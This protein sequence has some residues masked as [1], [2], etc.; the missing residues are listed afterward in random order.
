ML[1]SSAI[2]YGGSTKVTGLVPLAVSNVLAISVTSSSATISWDTNGDSTSQVFYGTA[3][4]NY[5]T[6]TNI[7]DY[8][9]GVSHHS[10]DLSGLSANITYHYKVQSTLD[11][12]NIIAESADETFTTVAADNSA[13][14]AGGGGGGSGGT[15]SGNII[16]KVSDLISTG[17]LVMDSGGQAKN[18]VQLATPDG[19]M[20]LDIPRG[21]FLYGAD[22]KPLTEINATRITHLMV[23]PPEGTLVLAYDFRPEGATFNPHLTLT[24]NYG[25]AGLAP[26]IPENSLN[27]VFWDGSQWVEVP[28]TVDATQHTL[29]AKLSRFSLYAL[30]RKIT[31]PSP[32]PAPVPV[33]TPT[34]ATATLIPGPQASSKPTPN[35]NPAITSE[36]AAKAESATEQ[37]VPAAAEPPV[38]TRV[39]LIVLF[40]ATVVLT[41]TLILRRRLHS[42]RISDRWK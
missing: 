13:G 32:S 6:Q 25:T 18:S 40:T 4:V 3:A 1:F 22:N 8:N 30:V 35:P 21:T 29:S 26:D 31:T 19:I 5:T 39:I 11:D 24:L 7:A 17:N 42:R 12:G 9:P 41:A 28:G 34:P 38:S 23:A 16:V 14:N 15:S 2:G 33:Q 10:I 27:L 20:A 37:P 36:P